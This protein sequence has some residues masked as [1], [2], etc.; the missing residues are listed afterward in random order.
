M[1]PA[2][3]HRAARPW[4][5]AGFRERFQRE[6]T[7]TEVQGVQGIGWLET[8]QGTGWKGA[9]VGS[10]NLGAIQSGKPPCAPATSFL[11]QDSSPNPD[12]SSTGYFIC[13]RKYATVQLGASDLVR[14]GYKN[15]PSVLAAATLGDF[16]GMSAA[17]RATS[18]YEG[19]GATI[20]ARIA[21]HYKA[22]S[23]AIAAAAAAIGE[24]YSAQ[25]LPAPE[26]WQDE[27]LPDNPMILRGSY[28]PYVGVWQGVVLNPWLESQGDSALA[29]DRAFGP[30]THSGTRLFQR[31][32]SLKVDGIVGPRTWGKAAELAA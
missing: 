29:V 22:L 19:F 3:L 1:T 26:P 30:I 17:L 24:P 10:N 25:P 31:A 21:N 28:G 23:S 13:F 4:Y 6:P 9:G 27:Y 14:V 32:H 15:R 8:R 5:E 11:Y 18:Y 12:G 2:E 20:A 16:Y 7:L